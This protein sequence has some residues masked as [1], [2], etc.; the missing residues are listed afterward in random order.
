MLIVSI[1]M[2]CDVDFGGFLADVSCQG[3]KNVSYFPK[4]ERFAEFWE[5]FPMVNRRDHFRLSDELA[6]C[7]FADMQWYG[8][9]RPLS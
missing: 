4:P 3:I 5:P 7:T 8:F 2:V 6:P 9:T 1:R